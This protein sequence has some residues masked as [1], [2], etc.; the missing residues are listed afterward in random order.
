MFK[1]P[2]VRNYHAFSRAVKIISVLIIFVLLSVIG[3]SLIAKNSSNNQD[4]KVEQAELQ[5]KIEEV[6][7]SVVTSQNEIQN[8]NLRGV[9][10]DNN[11]YNIK[12]KYG[13]K[14]DENTSFL[15]VVTAEFSKP[16]ITINLRSET[17]NVEADKSKVDL[18]GDIELIYNSEIVLNADNAMVDYNVNAANG[19]GNVSLQSDLGTIKSEKFSV[20]E[21]YEVVVFEGGRV[22]TNLKPTKKNEKQ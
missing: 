17:A 1:R 2:E 6:G 13:Y 5:K 15:K 7:E 21:N 11:P 12:A 22:Q 8:P 4:V 9:D 19:F 18:K 20:S 3:M 14:V 10:K 16:N